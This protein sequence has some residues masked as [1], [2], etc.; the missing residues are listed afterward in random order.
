MLCHIWR[1]LQIENNILCMRAWMP[2]QTGRPLGGDHALFTDAFAVTLRSHRSYITLWL[3]GIRKA[4]YL[5]NENLFEKIQS[6]K[7]TLIHP[8][9]LHKSIWSSSYLSLYVKQTKFVISDNVY[10]FVLMALTWRSTHQ[11]LKGNR[12]W[13][14]LSEDTV[15][16]IF[17]CMLF[18]LHEKSSKNTDFHPVDA[19][20]P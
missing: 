12:T 20:T 19:M 17:I 3:L 11:I 7:W 13:L 2:S 10:K 18:S 5:V 14:F 1:G 6:L 16:S 4:F 15:Q 9:T 8:P